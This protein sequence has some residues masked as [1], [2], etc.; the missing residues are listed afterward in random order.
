[1][2]GGDKENFFGES[3][4]VGSPY[5]IAFDWVARN[6]Y[7]GNAEASEISLAQVDGQDKFR[8]RMFLLGN[9]G[10]ETG[11]AW[12][13]S[14]VVHP[15]SGKMF[16]LDKGGAGGVPRKLGSA[17]MNGGNPTI[18]A[19][20]VE[21]PEVLTLDLQQGVLYFATSASPAKIESINLDGSNRRLVMS[22]GSL[23][24]PS[25]LAAWQSRLFYLDPKFEK[26]VVANSVDGSNQHVLLDNEANLRTLNVYRKR[27]TLGNHPCLS[28]R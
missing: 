23:A 22:G 13:V 8:Y 3:E 12:P 11:V 18:L 14:L 19:K 4:I 28:N 15:D 21:P 26:V 24:K 6:M 2:G 9:N 17:D 27:L 7:I 25:G 10:N 20:L 5:C 16:W 1:M